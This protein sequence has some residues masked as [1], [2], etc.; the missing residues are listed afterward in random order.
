MVRIKGGSKMHAR[1]VVKAFVVVIAL[2]ALGSMFG[3]ADRVFA[4]RDNYM[5]WYYPKDLVDADRA[6]EAAQEAGK[7][8]ACPKE[9]E[10][11]KAKVDKAYEEYA[12]CQTPGP[13]PIDIACAPPTC[14]LTADKEKIDLGESASLS[15][16]VSGYV[17][18]AVL[19]GTEMAATGGTKTVTPTS[20][21][22]YSATITGAMQTSTC[23]VTVQVIPPPPPTC[24]L[25]ADKGKIEPGESVTLTMTTSGKATSAVLDG[26]EMAPAGGTKIVEPAA[27]TNFTAKVVGPGGSNTCSAPV[28][29]RLVLYVHFP[30][31]R[32][33]AGEEA[34]WFTNPDASNPEDAKDPSHKEDISFENAALQ[35]NTA[36]LQKAVDFVKT[37]MNAHITVT[38]HTDG[39]GSAQY[40]KLLS[41]RRAS[42]VMEYLIGQHAVKR[43]RIKAKGVGFS[44]PIAPEKT[45]DGKD[46]PQGRAK[47]RRVEIIAEATAPK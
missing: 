45:P 47:N 13:I 20:T 33:K 10:E 23:S 34:Q 9:F 12:A 15:L 30:F 37:N 28:A 44:E 29:M 32:P 35:N 2:I 6:L 14:E 7:D 11:A 22:T 21:T 42:A 3:C 17:K 26:T 1:T 43:G 38:G 5:Y 8:K 39:M 27:A 19:D 24:E 41:A 40:N 18:S 46:D 4:P 25:T 31:D 36:E 16:T